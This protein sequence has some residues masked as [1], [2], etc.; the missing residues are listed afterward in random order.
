MHNPVGRLPLTT[1]RVLTRLDAASTTGELATA[2]RSVAVELQRIRHLLGQTRARG[3]TLGSVE[4]RALAPFERTWREVNED[5]LISIYGRQD[6][7]LT[8]EEVEYVD[9]IARELRESAS[10]R[11][12]H[13]LFCEEVEIF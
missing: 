12:V 11:L 13:E 3:E 4:W 5:L 10:A 2:Y 9:L 1:M 6:T 8:A 7:E